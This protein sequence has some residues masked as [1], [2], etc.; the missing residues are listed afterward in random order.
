MTKKKIRSKKSQIF[1]DCGIKYIAEKAKII[2]DLGS[3]DLFQKEMAAYK[4]LFKNHIYIGMDLNKKC[5]T[6]IFGDAHNIPFKE[7]SIDAVICKA[8]LEHLP[9]P[10]KAIKEIIRILKDGGILFLY[11]PF[12]SVYHKSDFFRFT[13]DGISYLLR[14]FSIVKAVSTG[15]Y[16]IVIIDLILRGVNQKSSVLSRILT[17][18]FDNITL[19]DE[20]LPDTQASGYNVIAIK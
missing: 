10:H 3:G 6:T 15:N 13:K 16:L 17:K 5:L 9:E 12:L 2:L 18:I 1:F 19:F 7:R 20:K 4:H 8:L 11:V 14:D